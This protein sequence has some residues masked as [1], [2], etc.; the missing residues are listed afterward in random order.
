M[1]SW[2]EDFG[3]FWTSSCDYDSKKK[4]YISI[5]QN[6]SGEDMVKVAVMLA[7]RYNCKIVGRVEYNPD[8]QTPDGVSFVVECN[9]KTYRYFYDGGRLSKPRS[10]RIE[11]K[12]L[13][14]YEKQF[15]TRKCADDHIG[16]NRFYFSDNWNGNTLHFPSLEK[17][18]FAASKQTG[19]SCCIYEILPYGRGS[20]IVCNVSASGLVLP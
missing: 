12:D 4:I 16:K 17:A 20:K 7:K 13:L 3:K 1:R 11:E 15:G 6:M 18:R 8:G 5:R 9:S 14:N 10:S 2:T 19:N